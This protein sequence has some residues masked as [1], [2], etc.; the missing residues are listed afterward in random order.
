[1]FKRRS[2]APKKK[3]RRITFLLTDS[4]VTIW[5]GLQYEKEKIKL[6]TQDRK[7]QLIVFSDFE[8]AMQ[9]GSRKTIFLFLSGRCCVYKL[10]WVFNR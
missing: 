5:I 7:I 8:K 4:L 10:V 3:K 9:F 6:Y 2:E 1:M